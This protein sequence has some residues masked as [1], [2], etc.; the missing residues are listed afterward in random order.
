MSDYTE[1]GDQPAFPHSALTPRG[2]EMYTDNKGMTL[3][4]WYAGQA[5]S[6]LAKMEGQMGDMMR[7]VSIAFEYA[8]LMIAREDINRK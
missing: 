4:Q 7:E 1:P 2:P 6:G 8:D 5:L 3:R